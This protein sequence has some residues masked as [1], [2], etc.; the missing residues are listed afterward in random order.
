MLYLVPVQLSENNYACISQESID[1]LTTIRH[2]FV[3][4]LKSARRFLRKIIPN[5]DIDNSTF[6]ILN[7]HHPFDASMAKVF[8]DQE[9]HYALLS[10]AGS[11]AVADPGSAL[12]AWAHKNN[13][14]VKPLSGPNSIVLA[15]MASG[16]NGQCFSF[17]GYL[18]NKKE[19]LPKEIIQ[20]EKKS[21]KENS[22]II[23]IETPYRNNQMIM[24]LCR[25][26]QNE[27][28]LCVAA[29]LTSPD[30]IILSKTIKEWRLSEYNFHKIPA[31]FIIYAFP[32]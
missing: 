14:Q 28:K 23:F 6:F 30:E 16:F 3:E 10:D 5:F 18:S 32:N 19:L 11:P 17:E 8:L 21:A 15:L 24:N 13:I 7:E 1:V 22:S 26:L 12:V 27:T 29:N 2:F 4:D 25:Y 31:V 20:L 9:F